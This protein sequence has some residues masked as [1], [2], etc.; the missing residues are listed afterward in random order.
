[1]DK[2]RDAEL[3]LGFR[4][5][6]YLSAQVYMNQSR[7][8]PTNDYGYSLKDENPMILI[9]LFYINETGVRFRYAFGETFMKSPRGN[10]FSMGTRYPVVN[11]NIAKGT[12]W[13]GGAF[14]YLRT[15]LKV[16]KVFQSRSWGHTRMAFMAGAVTG[17]APYGKL[18]A[19]RGSYGTFALETEQSFGTMRFNE[20]LSDRF[21]SLFIKQDF[22]SLL[23]KPRGKFRPEIALVQN[24]G[25]GKL[26][27]AGPHKNITYRTME[28]GYYEGG[29]LINNIFRLSYL[30]YGMGA[31]Y[32]YGP[33][34]FDKPI[35]NFAFKLTLKINI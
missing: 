30:S 15:E 31:L 10:M 27:Q 26:V 23:F 13:F 22:G 6:K 14:E 12:S 4:A 28:K 34:A 9:N 18:Y 33:Y 11:L 35:D 21:V 32:R 5:L 29:L 3:S 19:G 1:M 25:F 16:T 8:V 24:I 2:V 17:E 7:T 20:F